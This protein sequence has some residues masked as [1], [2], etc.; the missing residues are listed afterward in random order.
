MGYSKWNDDAFRSRQKVRRKSGE[1]AFTYDRDMREARKQVVHKEM[2]PYGK[3]RESR[4]SK[5]H[6]TSVAIAVLF[7]VT[8]SM[9]RLPVVFQEKLGDLMGMLVEK[10]YVSHPQ[11]LFGANGDA[12]SDKVPLQIGQF[13]AG[14]EMDD[15]LGKIYLEGGG[16]GQRC[17]TYEL[18]LYFMAR[19]TSIDC[20]EKRGKRGYLFTIGDEKPYDY[21]N[22]EQVRRHIGDKIKEDIPIEA[23]IREVSEKYEYFHIVPTNSSHGRSPDIREHWQGLLGERVLMLEDEWAVSEAIALTIGLC[24]G[25]IDPDGFKRPTAVPAASS[26]NR[27]LASY[28]NVVRGRKRSR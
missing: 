18:G 15:D 13:E 24:E 9:A 3:I 8:G 17:E 14:I 4:D 20:Y 21:V 27:A 11:M 19:H 22:A 2:N 25:A 7:D 23:M 1:T 16:G 26:A 10:D 5:M 12:Y 28:A 6:P